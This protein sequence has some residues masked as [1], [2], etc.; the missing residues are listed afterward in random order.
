MRH[1]STH[2]DLKEDETVK[3]RIGSLII[4]I[5]ALV[6]TV[7]CASATPVPV[8]PTEEETQVSEPGG[9]ALLT[10]TGQVENELALSRAELEALGV[11]ERTIEHPK[12]GDQT[13]TGVT[14]GRLLEEAQPSDDATLTFTA[15][16]AYSVDVPLSDARACADCM[17]TFHGESLRLI[18]PGFGSSF[19]VKDLVSI[20]AK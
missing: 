8:E 15:I 5:T 10:F 4:L 2:V 13:Y 18:M 6:L 14:L 1:R 16:D 20:E 19:W 12:D 7:G 17:I 11:V 3:R 9:E